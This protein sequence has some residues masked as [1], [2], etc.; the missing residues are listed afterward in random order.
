RWTDAR[1]SRERATSCA[2]VGAAERAKINHFVAV[3]QHCMK[4]RYPGA[5][6]GDVAGERDACD[7]PALVNGKCLSL[8]PS[9]S[10]QV[11]QHAV[12]PNVSS[13]LSCAEREKSTWIR[14]RVGSKPDDDTCI[15]ESRRNAPVPT[16]CSKVDDLPVS[17]Q[18]G[19]N[20]RQATCRI[21]LAILRLPC[22]PSERV[23]T[24]REAAVAKAREGTQI[25]EHA[26]LPA[27]GVAHEAIRVEAI[28]I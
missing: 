14:N 5:L 13:R 20:L 17:P 9:Q 21:N 22:N 12:L 2:R 24:S 26:I 8:R 3:P 15:V 28:W 18:C 16:E 4:G 10:S 27:R 7:L 25:C 19:S 11:C 23:D 6:I 1:C